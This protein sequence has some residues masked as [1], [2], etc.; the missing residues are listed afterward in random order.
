MCRNKLVKGENNLT[1]I[2]FFNFLRT[3]DVLGNITTKKKSPNFHIG[4]LNKSI[5]KENKY[6]FR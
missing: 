4:I 3:I 1:T 5:V 2:G 6:V